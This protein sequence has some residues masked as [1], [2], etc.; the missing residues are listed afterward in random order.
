VNILLWIHFVKEFTWRKLTNSTDMLHALS[1]LA[2]FMAAAAQ[3]E[4]MC[5]LWRRKLDEFLLWYIDDA[6]EYSRDKQPA[7]AP[8]LFWSGRTYSPFNL[9]PFRRTRKYPV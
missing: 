7:P 6:Q 5:G 3:T 8:Q 9:L 1:G 2:K 4:Y